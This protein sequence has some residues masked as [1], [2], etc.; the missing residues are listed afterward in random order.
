MIENYYRLNSRST[1]ARLLL[2]AII[3]LA[4]S[5]AWLSVKW[6]IGILLADL[7]QPSRP[8][9]NQVSKYAIALAPL[10]PQAW[11]LSA[12]TEIDLYTPEKIADSIKMFE[13]SVRL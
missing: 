5:F 12:A 3:L 2:A 8:D 7:T 13:E 4:I 9:A 1:L 6:Q 11:W 10:H